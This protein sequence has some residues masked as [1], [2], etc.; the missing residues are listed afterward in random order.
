MPRRKYNQSEF[1]ALKSFVEAG[2]KLLIFLEEG[3][4][5]QYSNNVNYLLEEY[6]ISVNNDRV[7]RTF[8]Y[9][10]YNPK[11][12]QIRDGVLNRS[13]LQKGQL[14]GNVN[15]KDLTYLYP[16]G[17]TLN[18]VKPSVAILS[19]GST[20][21][22]P[23][24]PTCAFY[25]SPTNGKIVVFGA[26]LFLTD[27]YI[28]KEDNL[29]LLDIMMAFVNEPSFTL[30]SIDSL[31]PDISDYNPVPELALLCNNPM[32]YLS[33]SEEVPADYTTL[34][35]KEIKR[36]TNRPL[37]DVGRAFEEFQIEKRSLQMIR[38]HFETP[39]PP[40]EPAVFAPVFR[41]LTKPELELYDLDNEFSSI[42]NKL[43]KLA[44]KCENKDMGF[45]IRESAIILGLNFVP[46]DTQQMKEIV[47]NLANTIDA[48]RKVNNE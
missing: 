21:F 8:F 16:F 46:K 27:K 18:V 12:V 3:G 41:A 39:L 10:Y 17:A 5:R 48:Y 24:R 30:N 20:S 40:L 1:S 33:E 22:P 43:T 13:L 6:G 37:F 42:P 4:E 32:L 19:T 14:S 2:G 38:P 47:Y 9:K 23:N 26:G 34:F 45:F 31:N 36:I 25:Q 11:E 29:A 35:L 15:S 28:N 44:N 7:I